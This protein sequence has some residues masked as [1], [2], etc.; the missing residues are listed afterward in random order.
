MSVCLYWEREKTLTSARRR[1]LWRTSAPSKCLFFSRKECVWGIVKPSSHSCTTHSVKLSLFVRFT[2]PPSFQA[3]MAAQHHL[4]RSED[5]DH[6]W[7]SELH[8]YRRRE[9]RRKRKKASLSPPP[10]QKTTPTAASLM[11][12]WLLLS[13]FCHLRVILIISEF[14]PSLTR[15]AKLRLEQLDPSPL[16]SRLWMIRV[17]KATTSL[18]DSHDSACKLA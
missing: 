8:W 6:G 15:A 7:H 16:L 4:S 14:Q 10:P 11:L 5:I 1:G 9:R 2:P 18:S 13:C 17:T 12:R 3:K